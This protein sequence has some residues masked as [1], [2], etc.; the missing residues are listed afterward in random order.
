MNN[1]ELK[2]VKDALDIILRKSVS[3]NSDISNYFGNEDDKEARKALITNSMQAM[4]DKLAF[5]ESKI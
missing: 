1:E 2:L 4:R 5:L 3:L